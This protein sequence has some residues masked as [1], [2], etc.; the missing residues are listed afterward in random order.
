MTQDTVVAE[1][2]LNA[3]ISLAAIAVVHPVNVDEAL[4]CATERVGLA[5]PVIV[6]ATVGIVGDAVFH[7]SI[8]VDPE[9]LAII[10]Q[11]FIVHAYGI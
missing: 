7:T 1:S 9:A 6:L 11:E 4:V 2:T 5:V 10:L 3:S 8:T